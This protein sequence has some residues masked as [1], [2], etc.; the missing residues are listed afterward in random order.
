MKKQPPKKPLKLAKE[1][2]KNLVVKSGV[3][4]GVA[5][6]NSAAVPTCVSCNGTCWPQLGCND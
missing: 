6:P 5:I 3:V 1:T 2:L 4:A